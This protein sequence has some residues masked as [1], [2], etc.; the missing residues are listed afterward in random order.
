MSG[1]VLEME[2]RAP[3]TNMFIAA[4][5]L[6]DGV[7][8][9]VTI[10]NLSMLGALIET[11]CVTAPAAPFSLQ[12]GSLIASGT[13]AWSTK[14]RCGLR[15]ESPVSVRDWMAPPTNSRQAQVDATIAQI[16]S[17]GLSLSHGASHTLTDVFNQ[18]EMLAKVSKM[19]EELGEQLATDR[20]VVARHSCALQN[21]DRALQLLAA[22]RRPPR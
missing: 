11:P 2:S 13:V 4:A 9:P 1:S 22:L 17:G 12:R 18:R 21:I 16:R 5:L 7:S 20:D 10:R 3:R 8:A 14:N 15:F 6:L 19:I